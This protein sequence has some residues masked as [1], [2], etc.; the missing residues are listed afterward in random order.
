[1]YA[2]LDANLEQRGRR[3]SR[4]PAVGDLSAAAEGRGSTRGSPAHMLV[5]LPYS[6]TV[7]GK[8]AMGAVAA[9]V[10]APAGRSRFRR[11]WSSSAERKGCRGMLQAGR[12]YAWPVLSPDLA[13]AGPAPWPRAS[14]SALGAE[15]QGLPTSGEGRVRVALHGME[16]KGGGW[17]WKRRKGGNTA[18]AGSQPSQ[19]W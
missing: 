4:K 5:P 18:A 12:A 11:P 1:L 17:C 8:P 14:S 19:P 3:S 16:R 2:V 13:R 7:R 9:T 6:V 10:A 15:W